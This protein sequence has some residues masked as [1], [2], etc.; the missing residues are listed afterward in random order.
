[1]RHSGWRVSLLIGLTLAFVS[2]SYCLAQDG[3]RGVRLEDMP[4]AAEHG[5]GNNYALV[6]GI[7]DYQSEDLADLEYCTADARDIAEVLKQ[8]CV[9]PRTRWNCWKTSR[10]R[11]KTCSKR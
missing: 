2:G 3:E 11:V 7:N 8:T 6:I 4:A 1:M 9:I 10:R 5:T